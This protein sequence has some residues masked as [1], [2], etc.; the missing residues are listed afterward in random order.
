MRCKWF[1]QAA[2]FPSLAVLCI[3]SFPFLLAAHGAEDAPATSDAAVAETPAADGPAE[4]GPGLPPAVPDE[5][6]IAALTQR[7]HAV[8]LRVDGNLA[9]RVRA[10]DASGKLV[11][12]RATISFVQDGRAVAT[13]R[14]D[15]SG[16]FQA[17]GLRPGTYSVVAICRS[18]PGDGR[19]YVGAFSVRV[20]A[21]EETAPKDKL[22][23]DITLMPADDLLKLLGLEAP[24]PAPTPE[25]P[26]PYGGGGGGGGG[27]G[28][29]ALLGLAGLGGLAGLAGGEGLASPHVP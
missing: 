14:S 2:L 21:F 29:G 20:L 12:L 7:Y 22:L 4:P 23:L 25:A 9:G 27:G 17:V 15:E 1:S 26:M 11:P 8:H 6:G 18:G 16:H 13:V 24:P 5:A 3:L 19:Q 10:M 28:L